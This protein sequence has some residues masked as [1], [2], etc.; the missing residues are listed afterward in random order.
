MVKKKIKVSD[1]LGDSYYVYELS[2]S[3]YTPALNGTI[4]ITCTMKD[5]YG[6][7]AG[8]KSITLY[9]NG[10]S[11]GAQTTNS[12]GVATWSITCS[13]AGIQ[14][15][16][17]K[18]T[19]IEVF[20]DNKEDTS[21]KVTSLS[22]S[23][24][25]TQYP[26]AKIVYDSL[27]NL[28]TEF[29][30]GTFANINGNV[31]LAN[32][33]ETTP[34]NGDRFYIHITNISVSTTDAIISVI[35]NNQSNAYGTVYKNGT[36]LKPN[37]LKADTILLIELVFNNGYSWN[38]IEAFD[39]D[40][41]KEQYPI[42][43]TL[44]TKLGD[45]RAYVVS[46]VIHSGKKALCKITNVSSYELSLNENIYIKIPSYQT[47][48][49][50]ATH[51]QLSGM[52]GSMGI[53]M[54]NTNNQ[55]IKESDINGKIIYATY[56][57]SQFT[58]SNIYSTNRLM[59]LISELPTKTSD[60]QNDSG[61]LTSHQSLA[62]YVQKSSTTGL[63]KN[64]GSV[65]TTSYLSSLPS[66]T[67]T[68]S[69]VSDVSTVN[70]VVTY[71][72]NTTETLQLLSKIT[73]G[74][75]NPSTT[76]WTFPQITISGILKDEN[77]TPI[78]NATISFKLNGSSQGNNGTYPTVTTNQNGEYTLSIYGG[79]ASS[80]WYYKFIQGN[81]TLQAIYEGN[82]LYTPSDASVTIVGTGK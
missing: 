29:I 61:F 39:G 53:A 49:D 8:N 28:R 10:T 50:S 7:V 4:T 51:I 63:L 58:V 45:E 79:S 36:A 55:T 16:S 52:D 72:D 47:D 57:G 18:D 82:G 31:I 73:L 22:S 56:G 17:I 69:N 68:V 75:T 42:K 44:K 76:I 5:V 21:N 32:T 60:L 64:D 25:D 20:V 11:K 77:N 19:S 62:N 15:F 30:T 80:V 43:E 48:S 24:T 9:Q 65:D 13:T 23:S 2:S 37:V 6:T 14:S 35:Y 12:S 34:T 27:Q 70:V 3:N 41:T 74:T 26:S 67:H 54:R 38:I 40:I 71:T 66:H 46:E 33:S 81:N 78:P 1:I 59:A